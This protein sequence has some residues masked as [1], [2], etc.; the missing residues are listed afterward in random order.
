MTV[1]NVILVA[2]AV[3]QM[4]LGD[5]AFADI[6]I[7]NLDSPQRNPG[8][9]W[10]TFKSC[11]DLGE[12]SYA[13]LRS[14]PVLPNV[15]PNNEATLF[16]LATAMAAQ[17]GGAVVSYTYLPAASASGAKCEPHVAPASRLDRRLRKGTTLLGGCDTCAT[18][19]VS[20]GS[21]QRLNP[22]HG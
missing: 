2:C 13:Q 22:L 12:L 3:L 1:R 16:K 21:I 20:W 19:A 11:D 5:V 10:I 7:S 6:A 9:F 18:C 15:L 17:G 4:G 14:L 8:S